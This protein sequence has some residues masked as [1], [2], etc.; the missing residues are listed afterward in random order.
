MRLYIAG[1]MSGI[2]MQNYPAFDR[3]AAALRE[4]GYDVVSPADLNRQ[5]GR[6]GDENAVG[7]EANRLLKM[8]LQEVLN[9]DAL[10]LLPGWKNSQGAKLEV[11]IAVSIGTPL[12]FWSERR[13]EMMALP[14]A[15]TDDIPGIPSYA[16]ARA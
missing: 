1:P 3:A 6:M 8:D 14:A 13:Q 4:Q 12:F 10:V 5:A 11:I 2:P 7:S 15:E 16:R 9:V